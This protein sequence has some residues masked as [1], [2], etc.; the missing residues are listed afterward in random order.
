MSPYKP[1]EH[2]A[3]LRQGGS[4]RD[5]SAQS[6][7]TPESRWVLECNNGGPYIPLVLSGRRSSNGS[8]QILTIDTSLCPN[9][10]IDFT[11]VKIP[12]RGVTLQSPRRSWSAAAG[13]SRIS[14]SSGKMRNTVRGL[15]MKPQ[16]VTQME[17]DTQVWTLHSQNAQVAK[18]STVP[19]ARI[20]AV[21][22][23]NSRA[24]MLASSRKVGQPM[25]STL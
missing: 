11:G 22:S 18:L 17:S 7:I 1:S 16:R 23:A 5:K 10:D 2:S 13:P 12:D 6:R 24:S 21:T 4:W 14:L 9:L 19:Q 8:C 3:I 15:G 25:V 20:D